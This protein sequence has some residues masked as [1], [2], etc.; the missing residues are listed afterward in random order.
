MPGDQ[1]SKCH[2]TGWFDPEQQSEGLKEGMRWPACIAQAA[3]REGA[4]VK[5][6]SHHQAVARVQ[7]GGDLDH[8]AK[9]TRGKER[10]DTSHIQLKLQPAALKGSPL[11][12]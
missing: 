5:L 12:V 10:L 1:A 8:S 7:E 2:T 9:S 3:W 11:R 4:R 6:E